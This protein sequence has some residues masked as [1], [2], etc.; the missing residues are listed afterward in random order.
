MKIRPNIGPDC[1][2]AANIA[3]REK[4]TKDEINDAF[5]RVFDYKEKL[6][7][8]GDITDMADKLRTVAEKE[9]RT[10]AFARRIA[11]IVA[12]PTAIP[13]MVRTKRSRSR[14]RGRKSSGPKRGATRLTLRG[15]R[16][17]AGGLATPAPRP[18]WNASPGR[19]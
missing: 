6:R 16:R 2:T 7:A 15:G 11:A 17:A 3:S 10:E 18:R 5:Q 9:A 8:S 13:A 12:T 14:R 4:L 19:W 1:F